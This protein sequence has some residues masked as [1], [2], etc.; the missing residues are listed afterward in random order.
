MK[1]H[2]R[3]RHTEMLV[4]AVTHLVR[5]NTHTEQHGKLKDLTRETTAIITEY[6]YGDTLA[7]E[8][9]NFIV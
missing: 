8:T 3:Y 6:I 1:H 7:A 5:Q 2:Q 9:R 4:L